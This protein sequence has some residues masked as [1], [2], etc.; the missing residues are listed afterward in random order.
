MVDEEVAVAVRPLGAV[1]M[2]GVVVKTAPHVVSTGAK[3]G[4]SQSL[5]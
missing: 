4:S 1:G 5:E 2:G 3:T